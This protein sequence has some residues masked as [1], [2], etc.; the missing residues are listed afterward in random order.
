MKIIEVTVSYA[1]KVN[2]GNYQSKDFF[3]SLKAEVNYDAEIGKVCEHL[4]RLCKK[5]V[6]RAIV[7]DTDV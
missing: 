6:D 7:S 4:D 1:Q 5:A 3:C 2:T